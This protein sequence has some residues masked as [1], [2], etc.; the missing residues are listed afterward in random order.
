MPK[1]CDNNKRKWNVM[2]DCVDL[3]LTF[4]IAGWADDSSA[5]SG[6]LSWSDVAW[7]SGFFRNGHF[8]C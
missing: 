4:L 6:V 7:V 8:S 3:V 5:L 2:R 1:R